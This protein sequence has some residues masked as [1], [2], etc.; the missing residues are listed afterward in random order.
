MPLPA[1]RAMPTS[2]A[3]RLRSTSK[4]SA[5]NGEMYS[6]RQRACFCGTGENIRRS[7]AARNAAS[8]LPEPV[9][10]RISVEWPAMSG[11]PSAWAR[12]GSA[13]VS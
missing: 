2:G 11:Q 4:A 9:G 13:N 6:T 10:A 8:V 3:R 12:V 5:R 1:V 7:M